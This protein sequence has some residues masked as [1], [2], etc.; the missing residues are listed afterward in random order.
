MISTPQLH[1]PARD[2]LAAAGRAISGELNAVVNL[3]P[4]T[5]THSIGA[6]AAAGAVAQPPQVHA[7]ALFTA[8][9][10]VGSGERDRD[11]AFDVCGAQRSGASAI[12][13]IA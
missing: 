13:P 12:R 7:Q 2:L 3:G 1:G 6:G 4:L 8:M 10:Q 11:D 9:Q 5:L